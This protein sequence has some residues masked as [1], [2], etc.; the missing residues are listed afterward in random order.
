MSVAQ[1]R[2]L[3]SLLVDIGV[4]QIEVGFPSASQPDDDFVR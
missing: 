4:K 1:K 2:R 3:W